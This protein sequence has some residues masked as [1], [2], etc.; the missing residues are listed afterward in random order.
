MGAKT[1][2]VKQIYV[3]M[4]VSH[5][6]RVL[7]VALC[8]VFLLTP[9]LLVSQ[10]LLFFSDD[11]HRDVYR[12]LFAQGGELAFL[13]DA[14]QLHMSDVRTLFRMGLVILSLSLWVSLVNCFCAQRKVVLASVR[15]AS[16]VVLW[17][18]AVL[19]VLVLIGF[20]WLF[21]LF[22]RILFIDNYTFSYDSTLIQLYPES[23]FFFSAVVWFA[24]CIALA[25]ISLFLSQKIISV[26]VK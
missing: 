25:G 17:F 9:L 4:A 6:Q 16:K 15:T 20:S 1:F 11:A 12:Y 18:C 2:K 23:F 13:T 8:V 5:K 3:S 7:V 22:H 26:S 14:E 10:S 24:L 19:M 21:E